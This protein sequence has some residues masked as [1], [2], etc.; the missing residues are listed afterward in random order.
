MKTE[1]QLD[2]DWAV[3]QVNRWHQ[4]ERQ[5]RNYAPAQSRVTVCVWEDGS[6]E[7]QY[8]GRKLKW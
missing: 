4:V 1:R 8:K 5:D 6:V 2:S 7:I 3:G